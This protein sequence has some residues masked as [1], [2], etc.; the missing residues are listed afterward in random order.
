MQKFVSILLVLMLGTSAV[1]ACTP[2]SSN[3]DEENESTESNE[4]THGFDNT[5]PITVVSREDGS[6]TRSAFIELFEVQDANKND[7][8]TKEAVIA[9]KTDVMMTNIANDPYAIGYISLGSLNNTVKAVSID[10]VAATTANVKNGTY[11]IQRPFIIATKPDPTGLAKDFIDF[12]MSKE[13]QAIVEER[14]Y[15]AADENAPEYN[16]TKPSGSIVVGGSSSVTPLMEYLVQE[17]K[18]LNTNATIEV[19][20]SD[21]SSGMTGAMNGTYD[22]GMSS[23]ELKDTEAAE[24]TGIDIAVDGI[25]VIVNNNNPVTD[26]S[27]EDVMRIYTGEITTWSE[28]K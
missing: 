2:A 15:L 5:K 4:S 28:I 24:L 12:I 19:Q 6:G 9:D 1:S 27:A 23:R 16:G 21:S 17:Y 18:K 11:A 7:N 10:G 3:G 20:M 25:A 13:G 26:L 8:T 22:I 14:G